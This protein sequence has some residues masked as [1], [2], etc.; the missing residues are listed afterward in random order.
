MR[1]IK[2]IPSRSGLQFRPFNVNVIFL[3]VLFCV[4][5]FN[6]FSVSR[7]KHVFQML[8]NNQTALEC[9]SGVLYI[10]MQNRTP[11]CKFQKSKLSETVKTVE[12]YERFVGPLGSV[13]NTFCFNS[14]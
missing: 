14:K 13:A 11:K 10:S 9:K 7:H 6:S 5:L 8:S 1:K 4:G 3:R 12:T 2:F